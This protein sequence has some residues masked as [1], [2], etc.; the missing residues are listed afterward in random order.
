MAGVRPGLLVGC[1]Q[2]PLDSSPEMEG[3]QRQPGH[4]SS[5]S[6]SRLGNRSREELSHQSG[7]TMFAALR[8]SPKL[9]AN[10]FKP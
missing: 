1:G 9:S 7:K 2:Q 3:P 10:G 4:W 8:N 6:S 5:F